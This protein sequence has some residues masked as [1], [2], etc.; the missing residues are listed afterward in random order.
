[1]ACTRKHLSLCQLYPI[2]SR[3][4]WAGANA[5]IY[6]PFHGFYYFGGQTATFPDSTIPQNR[7]RT[8]SGSSRPDTF[9][10]YGG[11]CA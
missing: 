10:K 6:L 9:R 3:D 1:M 2:L 5:R 8:I 7:A 4:G 11:V